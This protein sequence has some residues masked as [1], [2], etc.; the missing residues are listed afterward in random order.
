[1]ARTFQSRFSRQ[2]SSGARARTLAQA[3]GVFRKDQVRNAR[4]G[5]L[6]LR[7]EA[8]VRMCGE[9]RTVYGRQQHGGIGNGVCKK[10]LRGRLGAV[11]RSIGACRSR[12]DREA[13]HLGERVALELVHHA[14]LVDLDGARAD[15]QLLRD[16][17]M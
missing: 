3:R 2:R 4:T 17:L 6:E 8:A 15:R 9:A 1:M 12:L 11:L 16:F 13:N 14:S 10:L 5:R 7:Y